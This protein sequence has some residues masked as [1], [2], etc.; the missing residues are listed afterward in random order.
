MEQK[1]QTQQ[2]AEAQK[3]VEQKTAAQAPVVTPATE[4]KRESKPAKPVKKEEAVARGDS[5]RASKRHCMYI[6]NFIKGKTVDQSIMELEQVVKMKRAIPYKGE[7]PHRKGAMMSG[8]YP[9]NA[10]K[11]FITMLKGLKGNILVNGMDLE[12]TRIVSG[13]S[14]WASRPAKRSGGKSKR[15]HVTLIAKE[16]A[17]PVAKKVEAK[18]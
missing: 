14:N 13:V 16:V 3:P 10:S 1:T 2:K 15:T 7:V 12:K 18:K 8:R 5:I 17:T 9:V 4:T 11:I 6:C